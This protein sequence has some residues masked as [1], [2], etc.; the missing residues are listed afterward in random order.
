MIAVGV[1]HFARPHGFLRIV[2]AWLP[3]PLILVYVSGAFEIAGGLGLFFQRVRPYAAWGL[4]ALY[5]AVFP[6]N[7]NQAVHAIQLADGSA[8]I[9]VWALWLRLPFQALFIAWAWWMTRP[10]LGTSAPGDP[11]PRP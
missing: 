2:P 8:P 1:L 9:P 4:I 7:V 11:S 3:A 6:A 10:D 5:V